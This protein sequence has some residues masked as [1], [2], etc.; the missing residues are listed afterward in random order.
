MAHLMITV[1]IHVSGE[2]ESRGEEQFSFQHLRL[3]VLFQ[4]RPAEAPI[5]VIRDVTAVH[6]LA[7]QIAQVVIRDLRH[8]ADR[9]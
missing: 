8:K 6:D 1:V 3:D 4:I 5:P 2:W 9:V 7:K